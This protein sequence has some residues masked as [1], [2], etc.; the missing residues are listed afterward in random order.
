MELTGQTGT[1]PC[2]CADTGDWK[3]QR[4]HL[5]RAIEHGKVHSAP[6]PGGLLCAFWKSIPDLADEVLWDITVALAAEDSTELQDK[7]Y[8]QESYTFNGSLLACLPKT[9]SQRAPDGLPVYAPSNTRPLSISNTDNRLIS[10]TIKHS[11]EP[12]LARGVHPRQRGFLPGRSILQNII[13]INEQALHAAFGSQ[14]GAIVFFDFKAAFPSLSQDF[15]FRCLELR[16]MPNK[17]R[18]IIRSLY[19]NQRCSLA[20]KGKQYPGFQITAGIKQGCPL[21]SL[22]FTVATDIL[23]RYLNHK[24]YNGSTGICE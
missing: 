12:T 5:R 2:I 19:H 4:R 21:S 8:G 7:A 1:R 16:G 15:L 22:L 13:D 10:V 20:L 11:W 9:P 14:E 17:P 23:L 3:I 24:P 18:N 6:G